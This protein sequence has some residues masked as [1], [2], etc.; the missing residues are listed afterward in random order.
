MSFRCF[1]S[2]L[3]LDG[4]Y[5]QDIPQLSVPDLLAAVSERHPA[6]FATPQPPDWLSSRKVLPGKVM[7]LWVHSFTHSFHPAGQQIRTFK[8]NRLQVNSKASLFS[9]HHSYVLLQCSL[10][11]FKPCLSS[12]KLRIYFY[13][14]TIQCILL[15]LFL[16]QKMKIGPLVARILKLFLHFHLVFTTGIT[17]NYLLKVKWGKVLS[18]ILKEEFVH[19]V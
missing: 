10:V 5:Q 16:Q 9:P 12:K 1:V 8:L 14:C 4:R 17:F 19:I 6:H 13:S 11:V 7:H 2:F 15:L 3:T 18:A